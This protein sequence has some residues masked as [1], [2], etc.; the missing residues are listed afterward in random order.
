[1][2]YGHSER[3]K[4]KAGKIFMNGDPTKDDVYFREEKK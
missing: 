4:D 2:S 1:M 3:E